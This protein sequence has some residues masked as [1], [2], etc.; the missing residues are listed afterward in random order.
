MWVSAIAPGHRTAWH[1]HRSHLFRFKDLAEEPCLC[2]VQL[3]CRSDQ[4]LRCY[5]G[6]PGKLVLCYWWIPTH[7]SR[8][9]RCLVSY[10][11]VY[12]LLGDRSQSNQ[13]VGADNAC[14]E[15]TLKSVQDIAVSARMVQSFS[16][17]FF[18]PTQRSDVTLP[19]FTESGFL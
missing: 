6:F 11:R 19:C 16:E 17:I 9:K 10:R 13:I 3:G 15:A 7:L 8:G 12:T 18:K 5:E 14:V 4:L 2:S 1:M